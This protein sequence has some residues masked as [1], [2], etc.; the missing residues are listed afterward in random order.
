MADKHEAPEHVW[1]AWCVG[2]GHV[3]FA[4]GSRDAARSAKSDGGCYECGPGADLCVA[5]YAYDARDG[6]R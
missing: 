6:G 5:K 4:H 2:C 1:V 3:E